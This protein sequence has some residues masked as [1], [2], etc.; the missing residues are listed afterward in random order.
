MSGTETKNFD[1]GSGSAGT[2]ISG[3]KKAGKFVNLWIDFREDIFPV[4]F[5][6][7]SESNSLKLIQR[8]TN[9]PVFFLPDIPVPALPE[10]ESKFLVS[11][12]LT[13]YLRVQYIWYHIDDDVDQHDL[14]QDDDDVDDDDDDVDQHHL[15]QDGYNSQSTRFAM[16]D[17][18]IQDLV[19]IVI[20]IIIVIQSSSW[21]IL[22]K[23]IVI[24]IYLWKGENPQG[25]VD[26]WTSRLQTLHAEQWWQ[27]LIR[28]DLY[29]C[30]LRATFRATFHVFSSR[31]YMLRKPLNHTWAVG[32]PHNSPATRRRNM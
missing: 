4:Y 31:F 23:K 9:S 5:Y 10:P 3:R 2:G 28:V 14:G 6:S 24:L 12:P 8:I 32:S 21:L 19:W 13:P 27:V 25:W 11:V 20:K 22:F 15:V 26:H 18:D 17:S 16:M 29:L 30:H 7:E 1:S